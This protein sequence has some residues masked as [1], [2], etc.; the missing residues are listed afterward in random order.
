VQ[1]KNWGSDAVIVGSAVV[2]RLAEG[3]PDEGLEAIGQFCRSLKGAIS[4]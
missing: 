3:T 1:V 4:L 2:K